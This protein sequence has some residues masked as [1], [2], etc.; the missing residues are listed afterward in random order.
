MKYK[1]IYDTY[2]RLIF[3]VSYEILR[4]RQDAEEVVNDTFI[5]FFNSIND[6]D[7]TKNIKYWLVTTAK[8]KAIDIKRRMNSRSLINDTDILDIDSF[9]SPITHEYD[10]FKEIQR[11]LSED[12]YAVIIYRFIYNMSFHN[13]AKH[14][15]ANIG[16]VTSRYSRAIKKLISLFNAE[17]A[18]K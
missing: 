8:N 14:L 17:E 1:E 6:I 15:D 9:A 12:E 7:E 18:K 16:T 10:I 4:I 3:Y 13:I 11:Y 2:S 5:S